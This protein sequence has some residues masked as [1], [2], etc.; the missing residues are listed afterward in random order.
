MISSSN[1]S[2]SLTSDLRGNAGSNYY[3]G[4]YRTASNDLYLARAVAEFAYNELGLR[5]MATIHDGDPYTS[6]LTGAF[7]VEF[8]ALGGAVPVVAEAESGARRRW[9]RR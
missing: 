1:T 5:R 4:Y 2:P 6:G 3:P 8:E 7:A 9:C